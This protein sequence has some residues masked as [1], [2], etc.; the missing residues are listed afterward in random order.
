MVWPVVLV[1]ESLSLGGLSPHPSPLLPHPLA[2][3][4]Q[5]KVAFH[6]SLRLCCTLTL[7]CL[8]HHQCRAPL[9]RVQWSPRVWFAQS[10]IKD[11]IGSGS[12]LDRAS[13]PACASMVVST[14]SNAAV[15]HLIMSLLHSNAQL[16]G[17]P[18]TQ[19]HTC[20]VQSSRRTWFGQAD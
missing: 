11:I 8:D 6:I 15:S 10:Y 5:C 9:G 12:L 17:P 19:S 18:P 2:T 3:S 1:E 4:N 7:N 13:P 16:P 14:Q 20:Q